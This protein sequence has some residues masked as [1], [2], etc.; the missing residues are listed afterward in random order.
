MDPFCA[1]T[2]GRGKNIAVIGVTVIPDFIPHF[3]R[4]ASMAARAVLAT[5]WGM[6][7]SDRNY[8]A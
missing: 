4:G 8:A 6:V 2:V 1:L 5:D 7:G 3:D